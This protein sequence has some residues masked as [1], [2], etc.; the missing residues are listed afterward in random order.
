MVATADDVRRVALS[1]PE[2]TERPSYGQPG[3]RVKDKLFARLHENGTSLVLHVPMEDRDLMVQAEPDLFFYTGHYRNYPFV[4]LR[5]AGVD[6]AALRSHLAHSWRYTA[7]KRIL[8]R[9]GA[10][11]D[12]PDP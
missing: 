11:V 5:F 8:Q 9:F 1:L 10:T 4:L 7:P 2:T 3:F 6:E 12:A